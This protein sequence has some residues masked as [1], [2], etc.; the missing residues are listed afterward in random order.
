[1]VRQLGPLKRLLV[2]FPAIAAVSETGTMRKINL[3]PFQA[4]G[5]GPVS[6]PASQQHHHPAKD[7]SS[8]LPAEQ[9]EWFTPQASLP[10]GSLCSHGG[11]MTV[12][13]WVLQLR[14]SLI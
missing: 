2:T 7:H 9:D 10:T 5:W 11:G 3:E 8:A 14:Y 4:E 6:S 1:M 12:E 13:R